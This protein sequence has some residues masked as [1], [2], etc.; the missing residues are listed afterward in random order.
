MSNTSALQ[1]QAEECS[2]GGQQNNQAELLPSMK[3]IHF[4]LIPINFTG[5]DN[6]SFSTALHNF[7][8]R[9]L[10]LT[11]SVEQHPQEEFRLFVS[12]KLHRRWKILGY[13]LRTARTSS[14]LTQTPV[15]LL[16]I[17]QPTFRVFLHS[18]RALAGS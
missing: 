18:L 2:G 6:L 12:R 9:S 10:A 5:V 7:I 13:T 16:R 17:I 14:L 11:G 15:R 1:R 3:M 4:Q 8:S